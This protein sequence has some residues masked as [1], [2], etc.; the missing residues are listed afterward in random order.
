[1]VWNIIYDKLPTTLLLAG[2][3]ILIASILGVII[4]TI[5]AL[6]KGSFF[7]SSSIVM[8]VLGMS[9]P[10]YFMGILV[11]WL[12]GYV[13]AQTTYIPSFPFV[14]MFVGI[15]YLFI[16]HFRK[17]QQRVINSGEL[18]RVSFKSL[19][20]GFG[21][22]MFFLSINAL[23][24]KFHIPLMDYYIEL[25]GTN[26][27]MTGSLYEVDAY[28]G[29]Y[30]ELKNLILPAF[31]LG[32]RPLA[33]VIQLT[34]SSMLD[35][36]SKDFIRTATAKGLSLYKIVVKHALANALTPVVTAISGWF[37]SL[38]TGALFIEWI[39]D[40]NGLGLQMF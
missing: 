21:I 15:I 23:I 2:T 5:S 32:I 29:S 26:L 25:P 10:S 4:G 14:I 20:I 19:G 12:F 33:V 30:M 28:H 6:K 11:A 9:G 3:S 7:D 34:R 31:T 36:M 27:N 38:L 37:A 8:A 24:N 22:W 17:N 13:W 16:D 1:K 18:L 35:I 39:F 40:W